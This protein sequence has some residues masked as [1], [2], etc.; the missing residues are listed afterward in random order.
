MTILFNP[1]RSSVAVLPEGGKLQ[2]RAFCVYPAREL[3]PLLTKQ[4][5][6]NKL[7]RFD[8]GNA[9]KLQDNWLEPE[10][11]A[12]MNGAETGIGML[13]S[14]K[15]MDS[16]DNIYNYL[17]EKLPQYKTL[18]ALAGDT[19][20][21]ACF[22]H[23]SRKMWDSVILPGL[24]SIA[25]R[26]DIFMPYTVNDNQFQAIRINAKV[27]FI[28]NQS[29]AGAQHILPY[30]ERDAYADWVNFLEVLQFRQPALR[31]IEGH[32]RKPLVAVP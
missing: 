6:D 16:V 25:L 28:W 11:V 26:D 7:V 24:S 15:A 18:I 20:G 9:S 31:D 8:A 22:S 30:W 23:L 27:C 29:V 21:L 19:I 5:T 32:Y 2:P 4:I 17:D 3:P 1:S 10:Y 12:F 14:N 13:R